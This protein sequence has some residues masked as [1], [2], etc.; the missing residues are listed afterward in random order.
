[1]ADESENK[2]YFNYSPEFIDVSSVDLDKLQAAEKFSKTRLSMAQEALHRYKGLSDAFKS[3]ANNIDMQ[4]LNYQLDTI[5]NSLL[6]SLDSNHGMLQQYSEGLLKDNE[7]IEKQQTDIQELNKMAEEFQSTSK[8]CLME[9][10]NALEQLATQTRVIDPHNLANVQAP[11]EGKGF[12]HKIWSWCVE[13]LYESPSTVYE[14]N[15]FKHEAW[16]CDNGVDFL[17]RLRGV[18]VS[19]FSKYQYTITKDLR[20][21][22]S[23]LRANVKNVDFHKVLNCINFINE[24]YEARQ[25][26]YDMKLLYEKGKSNNKEAE[27]AIRADK[28]LRN[29]LSDYTN[30]F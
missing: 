27:L 15:N 16:E 12:F 2:K 23:Y 6:N 14:W 5:A 26:Y 30:Y 28:L 29:K 25:R 4:D 17:Q 8:E 20:R 22:D 7:Y 10:K 24:A 21:Y 11:Y 9:Y 13:I 19:K 1:M 18:N 3:H